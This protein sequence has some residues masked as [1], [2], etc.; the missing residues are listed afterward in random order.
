MRKMDEGPRRKGG[1]KT[2]LNSAK[3]SNY[4]C[5]IKCSTCGAAFFQKIILFDWNRNYRT[6]VSKTNRFG[7]TSILQDVFFNSP[8]FR[9]YLLSELSYFDNDDVLC[10]F[11]QLK[12][13]FT[14]IYDDK[15]RNFCHF[16]EQSLFKTPAG[17]F[18]DRM[19][20]H[21]QAREIFRACEEVRNDPLLAQERRK[22]ILEARAKKHADRIEYF[23]QKGR[24]L[25]FT[26]P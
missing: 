5:T 25:G 6:Y 24:D 8:Q 21:H 14:N 9:D 2:V 13:I 15:R 17:L 19:K 3:A 18:L 23:S 7:N 12:F 10:F 22:L 11:D 20:E 4:C 1:L 16:I 26:K